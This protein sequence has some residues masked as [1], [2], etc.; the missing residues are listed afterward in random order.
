MRWRYEDIGKRV[1]AFRMASGLSADEV[2]Q[3]I[4]ISR[5]ALYRVEKGEIAKVDTL[6]RLSD[7][8]GRIHADAAGRRHR[9]HGVGRQLFR[10]HPAAGGKRGP[11]HRP[12]RSG[13]FPAGLGRIRRQPGTSAA[14][15]RPRRRAAPQAHAGRY[16]P[17]H[18]DTARAQAHLY[19]APPQH[20]EPDLGR[21]DRPLP[22]RWPAG[23]PGPAGNECC[24]SAT[25][26]HAPR[27]STWPG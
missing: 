27:S 15:K 2:A 9:I 3:K 1:K 19:A 8:L 26:R 22:E 6:E 24:A 5:T 10:T 11:D 4:G 14:R 21:A 7:L 12:G 16:R 18:G 23:P 13:V 25:R 20:R 17:D